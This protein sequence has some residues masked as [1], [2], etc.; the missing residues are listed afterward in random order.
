MKKVISF[1]LL[2]GALVLAGCAALQESRSPQPI[3]T[4]YVGAVEQ[5]GVRFG[6]R[7]QWVNPPRRTP[8]EA[9]DALALEEDELQ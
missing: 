5:K 8:V 9:E 4:N 2:A 6:T 7:V 1:C 3:D